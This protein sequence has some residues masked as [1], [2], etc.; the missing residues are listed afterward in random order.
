MP[1][2]PHARPR[3]APGLALAALFLLGGCGS[4]GPTGPT[5]PDPSITTTEL[6]DGMV[7]EPYSEGVNATG[8][9]GDYTWDV[10]SGAL[11][12]GL[13]A[14]PEDLTG[15][16]LVVTGVPEQGGSF[17]FV[18]QVRVPDGRTDTTRFTIDIVGAPAAGVIETPRLAPA[19]AGAIYT[20]QLAAVQDATTDY[21][22]SVVDGALPDG[23]ELQAD[24]QFDG[25]PT[26][27]GTFTFTVR[28]SS[29]EWTGSETYTLRV[30]EENP[31]RY[32]ITVFPVVDVPD[33]LEQNV[34]DA[35][36]RWEAAIVGDVP[37]SITPNGLFNPG[38]CG[39]F[40]DM[41][42]GVPADDILI[43][44]NI[45][46]I[47]GLR[48][49]LAQAGPCTIRSSTGIPV[50][51]VLTLDEVDLEAFTSQETVTDI[52]QHEMGHVIGMGSLWEFQELV[53]GVGGVDPRYTG[54][55]AVAAYQAAG[56]TEET[57]PVENE[58]GEGTR[59]SHWRESVFDRELMTGFSE[60][61]GVDMF[62]SRMSIASLADLGYTVDLAAADDGDLLPSLL[63]RDYERTPDAGRDI[64][65]YGPV[66]TVPES[67][68]VRPVGGTQ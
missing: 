61:D 14:S 58:G 62:L 2:P 60:Q 36:A 23:L 51:G 4:D 53:T 17:A 68:P 35:V 21:T 49:V 9:G 50:A 31:D 42:E 34:A 43:L 6:A 22:W 3:R 12:P 13:D 27:V 57:I 19:L 7:G 11:P 38:E 64:V 55:E 29:A 47:D 15:D 5:T 33:G 63:A 40:G 20:V 28:A 48:G 45:D 32:D 56:G 25:V 52:I 44:V 65:G 1:M 41:L 67:I 16:D 66:R 46:S 24:G 18:L 37:A 39:G 54:A 30:V 10:L 26:T 8:G 59:D